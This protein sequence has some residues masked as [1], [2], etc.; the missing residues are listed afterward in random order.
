M[1]TITA[2]KTEDDINVVRCCTMVE[3][4]PPKMF[5]ESFNAQGIKIDKIK[6]T[7]EAIKAI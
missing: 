3:R 2:T 7:K 5:L 1:Y 6:F 4:I